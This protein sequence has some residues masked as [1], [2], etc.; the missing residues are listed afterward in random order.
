[1]FKKIDSIFLSYLENSISSHSKSI[2]K[3]L[4]MRGLVHQPI[5][6]KGLKCFAFGHSAAARSS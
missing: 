1:M 2:R 5:L 3:H 4:Y 6:F